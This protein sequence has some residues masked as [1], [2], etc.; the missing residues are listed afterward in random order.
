MWVPHFTSKRAWERRDL[1]KASSSLEI[2]VLTFEALATILPF[3]FEIRQMSASTPPRFTEDSFTDPIPDE[4]RIPLPSS[5][6]S[7]ENGDPG[8]TDD[9]VIYQGGEHGTSISPDEF[10]EEE[11]SMT[12][13][14]TENPTHPEEARPDLQ[15]VAVSLKNSIHHNSSFYSDLFE[16]IRKGSYEAQRREAMKHQLHVF[17]NECGMH[18]R[19]LKIQ[20]HLYRHLVYCFRNDKKPA[21]ASFYMQSLDLLRHGSDQIKDLFTPDTWPASGNLHGQPQGSAKS[22]IYKLQPNT[23]TSILGFLNDIR[24][25]PSFL[26]NRITRLSSSQLNG[27]TRPHRPQAIAD[28]VL[29]PSTNFGR[30]DPRNMNRNPSRTSDIQNVSKELIHDPLLLLLHGAFGV[31]GESQSREVSRQLDAWSSVCAR[32]IDDGKP[33]SDDFCLSVIDAF[34]C[35]PREPV[36]LDLENY[37]MELVQSGSFL[38]D[39]P[40]SQILN[41]NQP[42]EMQNPRIAVATSE[43]FDRALHAILDLITDQSSLLG[44]PRACLDLI[45]AT[46]EKIQ[47]PV[48]RVKARNFF[49]SRW[50]SAS[51]L[52]NMLIFPE[53]SVV[54]L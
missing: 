20:A 27:L 24:S 42:A 39:P 47:N 53:V 6:A 36:V 48:R 18:D 44:A 11:A 40:A 14:Q 17:L 22:W 26:A 5:V 13:A 38:L 3:S 45:R 19:L 16:A 28:S 4:L 10:R 33:G 35:F 25:D 1:P 50:Y 30:F 51:F 43:F 34:P 12:D 31:S 52:S 8:S 49:I 54:V 23:Q 7:S 37:L 9:T 2:C 29:G 46:L 41:F 15:D 32:V 21:F